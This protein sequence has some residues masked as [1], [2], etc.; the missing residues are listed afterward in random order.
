MTEVSHW[1]PMDEAPKDGQEIDLWVKNKEG[2]EFRV[3]DCR[4]HR[5]QEC[6][7]THNF[8]GTGFNKLGRKE[9]LF[10]MSKPKGPQHQ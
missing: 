4:W 3:A 1:R 7:K 10:W 8:T 6:W 2:M 5:T 9:I